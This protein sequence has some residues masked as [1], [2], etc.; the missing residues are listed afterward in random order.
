[1]IK[2]LVIVLE[3]RIHIARPKDAIELKVDRSIGLDR[4]GELMTA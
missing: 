2:R 1:M 4:R 3:F